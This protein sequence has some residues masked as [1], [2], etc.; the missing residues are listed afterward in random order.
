MNQ[1]NKPNENIE[2]FALSL[3]IKYLRVHWYIQQTAF[4]NHFHF[5]TA[6]L[7]NKTPGIF[8]EKSSLQTIDVGIIYK[9]QDTSLQLTRMHVTLNEQLLNKKNLARY[10]HN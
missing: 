2:E 5:E 6:W 7:A 3:F 8:G 9:S 1:S 4:E 10:N